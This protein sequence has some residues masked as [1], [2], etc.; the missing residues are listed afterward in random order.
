MEE[1]T[2]NFFRGQAAVY[3]AARPEYPAELY[4]WL[5][6]QAPAR[7]LVWEAGAGSGQAS[8]GLAEVFERVVATDVAAEQI[9][10]ARP[11]PRVRY[12][13]GP[14]ADSGLG[15]GAAHAV[16]AATAAHWF[17][18]EAFWAEARRVLAPGGLVAVW[19]Y[20]SH[21]VEGD[22]GGAIDAAT[23]R[24]SSEVVGGYWSAKLD[25][26]QSRYATLPFPFDALAP[27]ELR[28]RKRV[29]LAGYMAYLGSW[30]ASQRYREAHGAEPLDLARAELE[31]AW[32][33]PM[34]RREVSWD[35][36]MRAGRV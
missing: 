32:G 10:R 16:V 5:A 22:E 2:T 13:V 28:A 25:H 27:P 31:A 34:R 20:G 7:G 14:E 19:S 21:R 12:A 24:Y 18:L 4:A 35:I 15:S 33:D 36:F 30:S 3:R 1:Q 23:S 29:D 8:V 26:I 6:A 17:D 9:G 11:H